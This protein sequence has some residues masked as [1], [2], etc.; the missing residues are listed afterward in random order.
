MKKCSKCQKEKENKSFNKNKIQK[1]GLHNICRSCE[2]IYRKENKEEIASRYKVYKIKNKKRIL[3]YRME[4][5]ERKLETDR[6]YRENNK[7]KIKEYRINNFLINSERDKK[8]RNKNKEH[9]IKYSRDWKKENKEH[10]SKVA[11]IWRK[12]NKDKKA[13]SNSKRRAHKIKAAPP[14][15]SDENLNEIKCIYKKCQ[16][17]TKDTKIPHHVDHIVPL[18]GKNVSGLHVPWNLQ[19]ITATENLKKYNNYRG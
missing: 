17:I 13:A 18:Q 19:I 1:G 8:L 10:N 16:E 3:E 11:K 6:A 15:L 12:N 4:N 2:K 5:R 9:Y 7:Q 14:W